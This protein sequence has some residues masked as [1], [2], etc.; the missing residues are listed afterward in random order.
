M[1]VF[2]I[3][4]SLTSN[5]DKLESDVSVSF[6]SSTTEFNL[7]FFDPPEDSAQDFSD[8]GFSDPGSVEPGFSDPG[9]VGSTTAGSPQDELTPLCISGAQQG[10]SP[11][12]LSPV[13]TNGAAATS[14]VTVKQGNFK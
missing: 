11:D 9:S 6:D 3:E 12:L 5:H 14:S 8:P 10:A 2:K 13:G 4:Q 7:C 1:D